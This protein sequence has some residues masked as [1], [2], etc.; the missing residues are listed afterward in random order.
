LK[1]AFWLIEVMRQIHGRSGVLQKLSVLMVAGVLG[2]RHWANISHFCFFA[3]V[4][5][6]SDA[7][8]FCNTMVGPLLFPGG[9]IPGIA[10]VL[11]SLRTMEIWESMLWSSRSIE[12]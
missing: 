11:Y 7:I 9:P 8:R 10:L 6:W 5:A 4:S 12:N 1:A 3:A 2:T